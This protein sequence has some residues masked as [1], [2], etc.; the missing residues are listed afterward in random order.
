MSCQCSTCC[1]N[2][3]G[4]TPSIIVRGGCCGIPEPVDGWDGATD[5]VGELSSADLTTGGQLTLHA[6]GASA[7][8]PL[9]TANQR[10]YIFSY[11]LWVGVQGAFSLHENADGDSS[12]P[13][14]WAKIVGGPMAQ[15]GGAVHRVP[16]RYLRLGNVLH[17]THSVAGQ[18]DIVVTGKIVTEAASP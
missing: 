17:A 11:Q 10:I 6:M 5:F 13:G 2:S 4:E 9:P 14:G 12:L 1:G 8:L 15:Y 16:N 18:V 3:S 7:A